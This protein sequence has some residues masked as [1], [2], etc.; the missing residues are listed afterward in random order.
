MAPTEQLA[1]L[2]ARYYTNCGYG[3]SSDSDGR[4]Y[5]DSA[6]F[7]WGRWV[8]AGIAIVLVFAVLLL[9]GRRNSRR[10]RQQGLQPLPGTAWMAG[11]APPYYP[12]PP[13]YTAQ[14]PAGAQTPVGSQG[15]GHK[16]NQNDGYYANQEGV[17]LQEPSNTYQRGGDYVYAPPE[18][19]PPVAGNGSYSPPAGPPPGKNN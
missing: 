10:R 14:P 11:P 5:R 15:T 12:P 16:F 4:C 7:W 8:F 2:A 6:W 17:Q 9:V 19:P 1:S 18:G 13:Q 3:Y